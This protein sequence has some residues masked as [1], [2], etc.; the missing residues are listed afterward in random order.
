MPGVIS[1]TQIGWTPHSHRTQ[2]YFSTLS[3][4]FITPNNGKIV[5]PNANE[6]KE[7]K[8]KKIKYKYEGSELFHR[9]RIVMAN[10]IFNSYSNLSKHFISGEWRAS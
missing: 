6:R 8:K 1:S 4:I 7:E 9:N 3:F 5:S 2:I 10:V